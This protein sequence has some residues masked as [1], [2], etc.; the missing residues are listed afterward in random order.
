MSGE[1]FTRDELADF[2]RAILEKVSGECQKVSFALNAMDVEYEGA[3]SHG[4]DFPVL[5][6]DKD[7]VRMR[8]S[9]IPAIKMKEGDIG[10]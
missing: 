9:F 10:D 1:A 4:G 5:Q 6:A 8:F 7:G 2:F 3:L